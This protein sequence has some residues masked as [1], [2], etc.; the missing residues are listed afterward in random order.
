MNT[1]LDI[2]D[3]LSNEV[4]VQHFKVHCYRS[5]LMDTLIFLSI[6]KQVYLYKAGVCKRR[7]STVIT[8]S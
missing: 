3:C 5:M 2:I 4:K 6:A 1:I 7:L 8:G